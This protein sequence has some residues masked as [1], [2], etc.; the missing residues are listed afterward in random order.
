MSRSLRLGLA[1]L[2]LLLAAACGGSEAPSS[3]TVSK[4]GVMHKPGLT[5]PLQNCTGCH[6]ASLQGGSGPSCTRC[7]GVKW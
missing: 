6:G 2:A 1:T 7:H 3:H 5:A 4:D